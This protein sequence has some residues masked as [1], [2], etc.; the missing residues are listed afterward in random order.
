MLSVME[1][2]GKEATIFHLHPQIIRD[3]YC[4]GTGDSVY[5]CRQ[6]LRYCGLNQHLHIIGIWMSGM[7]SHIGQVKY[8]KKTFFYYRV[9]SFSF[10]RCFGQMSTS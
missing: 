4:S 1:I 5:I 8:R 3:S 7:F 6:R 2:I 9:L 10:K